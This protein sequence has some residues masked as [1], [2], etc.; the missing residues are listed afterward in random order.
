LTLG[1]SWMQSYS[2]ATVTDFLVCSWAAANHTQE[3]ESP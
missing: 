3:D 1:S 2:T